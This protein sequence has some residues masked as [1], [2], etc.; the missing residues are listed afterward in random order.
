VPPV[1]PSGPSSNA[2]AAGVTTQRVLFVA[3]AGP[4]VGGGHVMRC[5]TLARALTERGCDCAFAESRAAA[6]ILR[7]FGWPPHALVAM[8]GATD[9][10]GLVDWAEQF[11]D[12]FEPDLVVFDHYQAGRAEEERL[13]INGRRVLVIDDLADRRHAADMLLDPGFGRRREHYDGLTLPDCQVMVGPSHALVRP[14][15][16]HGRQ[17]ALSRRA[18]HGP[19][20]R[21]VVTLGMT[22]VGGVT[23]KVVAALAPT[24]GDVRLEVVVGSE[25][26]SLRQL[27]ALAAEDRRIRLWIDDADMAGLMSEA[28]LAVGAGGSSVWERATVGLP[29]LTLSLADNQRPMIEQLAASGVTVGLDVATSD[30]ET[31]LVAA[32]ASLVDD[33]ALRWRLTER[34]AE[35]CDGQGAARVAEVV[36]APWSRYFV[37]PDA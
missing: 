24:L 21:A 36:L 26:P 31:K 32:W 13:R 5:L 29:T 8:I 22:D 34:S 3:D 7:R 10:A 23:G 35:L 30:F 9:L 20:R 15:F 2:G 33:R 1:C 19:V 16:G 18:S 14:E 28:D 27:R 12:Q 11:A 25:A 17:R 4:Q 6:P 37:K